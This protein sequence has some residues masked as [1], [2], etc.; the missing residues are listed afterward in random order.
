MR[1]FLGFVLLL[2]SVYFGYAAYNSG[3]PDGGYNTLICVFVFV[4][5]AGLL[6]SYTK[7]QYTD[8]LSPEDHVEFLGMNE[9]QQNELIRRHNESG[10]VTELQNLSSSSKCQDTINSELATMIQQHQLEKKNRK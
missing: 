9:D 7:K 5:G 6:S 2:S 10:K 8:T 3:I 1:V 4:S